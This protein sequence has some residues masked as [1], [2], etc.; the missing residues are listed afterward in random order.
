L[1]YGQEEVE[2][3]ICDLWQMTV[4]VRRQLAREK[5]TVYM[6]QVTNG[7]AKDDNVQVLEDER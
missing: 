2:A 4:C 7:G 3:D 5:M 6:G 1:K